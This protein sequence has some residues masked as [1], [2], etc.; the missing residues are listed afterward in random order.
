MIFMAMFGND[1]KMIMLMIIKIHPEMALLIKIHRS[2]TLCLVVVAMLVNSVADRLVVVEVGVRI[3]IIVEVFVFV[4]W[5][6][7]LQGFKMLS[8]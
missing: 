2:M 1:V 7:T 5:S 8:I 3:T 4:S 6:L